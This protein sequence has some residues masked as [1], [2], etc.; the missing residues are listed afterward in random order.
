MFPNSAPDWLT[1]KYLNLDPEQT[2]EVGS[3][4]AV[5]VGP[6]FCSSFSTT[7][8]CLVSD[9]MPPP[10]VLTHHHLLYPDQI[11]TGVGFLE[12]W[13]ILGHNLLPHHTLKTPPSQPV[14]GGGRAF[15]QGQLSEA[16]QPTSSETEAN[17]DRGLHLMTGKGSKLLDRLSSPQGLVPPHNLGL[18]TAA[19]VHLIS[20]L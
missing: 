18:T 3:G 5:V 19:K 12:A 6:R 17:H 8:S 4:A 1:P 10:E 16:P 15:G 7:F 13:T 20:D 11:V 14:K 9:A 2:E